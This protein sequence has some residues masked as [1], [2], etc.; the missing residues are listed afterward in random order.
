M[1][2]LTLHADDYLADAIR[3][4]ADEA[5]RSINVFLKELISSS[6]GLSARPRK[7]PAFMNVKRRL[8]EAGSKDLLS[9]QDSFFKIKQS[10]NIR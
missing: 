6:L 8:T 1:T 5:G 3:T 9:V 7:T 4:A 10:N 2:A